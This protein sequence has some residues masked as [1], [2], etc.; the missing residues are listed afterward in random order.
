MSRRIFCVLLLVAMAIFGLLLVPNMLSAQGRSDEAFERVRQVQ[1]RHSDRLMAKEDVVGTA[2]GLDESNHA[3]LKVF[4]AKP[5]V[6]GIPK[7]LDDVPVQVVVTGK[8]YAL[9]KGGKPD[10]PG[11][12]G[13]GEKVDPTARFDRPVPIGVSTGNRGECSAGTI[14]CRVTKGQNV[15]ALSNNHVYALE[16]DA[17]LDSKVVQP[18]LYD[19]G[20]TFDEN[21]VIGTLAKYVKIEFDGSQ[22]TVDAAIASTDTDQLG[23]ATPSNGY[24]TPKSATAE[25]EWGMSVQKYGRTSSLTKGTVTGINA[26][27]K[28]GYDSGTALFVGQIIVE[29]R[30]AFIKPGDSGSLLVTAGGNNP[31]GL[32]F[33]GTGNGKLAV[34][35]QIDEVLGAFG[36][37]IDGK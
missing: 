33:A 22:N 24:G 4:T 26:T 6:A 9:P 32:L 3:A 18:G 7:K 28:V 10:K 17:Q 16:N 29:S 19:T 27:V 1:Q 14:A 34:A 5:G 30:R 15:Y 20:C 25:A 36:V 23:N 31:V 35:N 37:S 8:I 11:K 2:V 21:N 13:G 12:P